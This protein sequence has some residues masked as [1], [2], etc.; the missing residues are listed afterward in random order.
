MSGDES[1]T[2]DEETDDESRTHIVG[3]PD[4]VGGG[5]EGEDSETGSEASTENTGEAQSRLSDPEIEKK[6]QEAAENTDT[7]DQNE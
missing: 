6:M 1:E 5:P 7:D 2:P 4:D 3:S